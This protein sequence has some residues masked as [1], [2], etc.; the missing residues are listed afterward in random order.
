MVNV[1]PQLKVM[2]ENIIQARQ[3]RLH[4]FMDRKEEQRRG[5]LSDHT[6]TVHTVRT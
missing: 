4:T 5:L 6:L 2:I 1:A 3:A